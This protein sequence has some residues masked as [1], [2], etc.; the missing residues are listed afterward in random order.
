MSVF[1]RSIIRHA[2]M[3]SEIFR[4]PFPGRCK[5]LTWLKIKPITSQNN[6]SPLD[7]GTLH[8]M[9]CDGYTLAVDA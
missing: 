7:I 5:T 1:L 8:Y 4:N 2:G 9:V 6:Y 3:V